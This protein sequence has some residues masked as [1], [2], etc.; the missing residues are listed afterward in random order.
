MDHRVDSG[1]ARSLRGPN[2]NTMAIMILSLPIEVRA[3]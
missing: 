3:F 2:E 1:G